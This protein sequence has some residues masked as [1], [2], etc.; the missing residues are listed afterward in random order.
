[1]PSC[2]PGTSWVSYAG[3]EQ[4][5][6][7][8]SWFHRALGKCCRAFSRQAWPPEL[9]LVLVMLCRRVEVNPGKRESELGSDQ[10]P[11]LPEAENSHFRVSVSEGPLGSDPRNRAPPGWTAH[12]GLPELLAGPAC[13]LTP[14]PGAPC[15][16]SPGAHPS[17]QPKPG[18]CSL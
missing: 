14:I 4:G 15:Q 5:D 7:R 12:R 6:E 13:P 18:F 1:M 16:R 3:A 11:A 17:A 9:P 2:E 8:M 10:D